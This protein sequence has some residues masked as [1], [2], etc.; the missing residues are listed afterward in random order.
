MDIS[1]SVSLRGEWQWEDT[2]ICP[3]FVNVMRDA[4]LIINGRDVSGLP[5]EVVAGQDRLAQP[6]VDHGD[7]ALL[8]LV[9]ANELVL[10]VVDGAVGIIPRELK[11]AAIFTCC[12]L[13]CF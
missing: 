6:L 2:I 9:L 8:Q 12:F 4:I 7:G 1:F 10:P 5:R 13:S 3:C 11:L